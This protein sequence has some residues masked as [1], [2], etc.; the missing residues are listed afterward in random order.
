MNLNEVE[1]KI[2]NIFSN[3]SEHRQIIMWYDAEHEF[4]EEI[5]NLNLINGEILQLTEDNWMSTKYH[6]EIE[7]PEHNFLIY[8]SFEMYDD[9]DNYLADMVHY[10][11]L[12]NA[13]KVS[14]ICQDLNI[15]SKF[16]GIVEKYSKFWNA[17]QRVK[18][19]KS[20]NIQYNEENII[21]GILCVLSN[22]KV[23]NLDNVL[24]QI[25]INSLDE[26]NKSMLNFEKFDILENFWNLINKRYGYTSE[27]PNVKELIIHLILNYSATLFKE[28]KTP[29]RW[30][31]Y[32]VE[33]KNN[34]RVFIDQFMNNVNYMDIYDELSENISKT[35][36]LK[37]S[38][39]NMLTE[40]YINC[41]SFKE[42]DEYI[43]NHYIDVLTTNQSKITELEEIIITRSKTHFYNKFEDKYQ[44]IRWAND[45]IGYI[46]RFIELNKPIEVDDLINHF[47]DEGALIDKTYRNFYYHYDKYGDYDNENLEKLRQL[48]ENLYRNEYLDVITPRFTNAISKLESINAINIPKQW[49]FYRNYVKASVEKRTTI[50]IISDAMRYG[51]GLELAK[52][53]ED[54][55]PTNK[56]SIEPMLS[57]IPSYTSL[58]MAALLPHKDLYYKKEQVYINNCSATSTFREKILKKYISSAVAVQ[59][60]DII[61]MKIKDFREKYRD[62]K[63]MYIYHNQIDA[64]G[65]NAKTENEVF[66]AS[67]EAIYEIKKLIK[68]ITSSRIASNFFITADHGFIYKRDK[69]KES[70]KVDVDKIDTIYYNRRFLLT[71]KKLNLD[72]TISFPLNYI[73]QEDMYVTV[74]KSTDVFKKQGGGQNFVHGGASLEECII[75]LIKLKTSTKSGSKMQN[76]VGLQLL[77]SSNKITNNINSFTFFQN[78]NVSNTVLPL[79]AGIY[80]V[81]EE[82]N[83]IS[84]DVI[85]YANINSDLAEDRE[86]IEKFTLRQIPY[87]KNN[88]YYMVIKNLKTDEEI[89]RIEFIIDLA[90]QDNFNFI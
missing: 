13:D 5:N 4:E 81:D 71:E 54:E 69:L 11:T 30:N 45:F 67:E 31:K 61:S 46:N 57:T 85:I 51:I 41:D 53:L 43:T 78:E 20:L 9:E 83:K 52:E 25:I 26:K 49:N 10:S 66:Q 12:F 62:C 7:E 17:N 90:F 35:I 6:V 76:T 64:R 34:A 28:N 73:N 63:L 36:N 82:D 23:L 65:D 16:K 56:I 59:Y 18:D 87:N 39:S 84:N 33:N 77:S 42:F 8:A 58:G 21:I 70:S 55:D 68:K 79:E 38:L 89:E 50:V 24:S 2:N 48:I 37:S 27:N 88:K 60:E 40:N 19:F 29:K 80:F 72:G 1:N 74:P 22:Q 44:L 86:F 15:P 32:L 47:I 3:D 14:M 75:P